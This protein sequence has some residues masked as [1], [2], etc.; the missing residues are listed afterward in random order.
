[1][2]GAKRVIGFVLLTLKV[3]FAAAIALFIVDKFG[4]DARMDANVDPLAI[5]S[6]NVA[7]VGNL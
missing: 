1:L 5:H 4:S 3:I 7:V 2:V 6:V